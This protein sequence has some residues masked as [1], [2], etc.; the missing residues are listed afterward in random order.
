MNCKDFESIDPDER[1]DESVLEHAKACARCGAE[2][3]ARRE[4]AASLRAVARQDELI[5]APPYIETALL[6][7]LR[8]G[9]EHPG[10]RMSPARIITPS[11][12]RLA[13]AAAAAVI[14]VA[15]TA[16]V[17]HNWPKSKTPVQA[18]ADASQPA[19]D[20]R[21]PEAP[22]QGMTLSGSVDPNRNGA[23]REDES[24]EPGENRVAKDQ[25]P[26]RNRSARVRNIHPHDRA[27]NY[28][29]ATDYF[30]ISSGSYLQPFDGGQVVRI[31]LPR[32]ALMNYGLPVDPLRADEAVKADVVIGNDGMA[33]AIRFVH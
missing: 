5:G 20:I 28:E 27:D 21:E 11:R 23:Q 6:E 16:S 10:T 7:A 32:S 22:K 31:R 12:F 30:P 17:I 4:L 24:R 1:V 33:R 15:V 3:E 13:L 2:L 29:I 19:P 8:A 26:A 18:S 14:L 9:R 25:P